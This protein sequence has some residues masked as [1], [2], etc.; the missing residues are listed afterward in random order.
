MRGKKV[1]GYVDEKGKFRHF[2]NDE[3]GLSARDFLMLVV[4]GL[5]SVAFVIGLIMILIV[6]KISKDFFSL[7]EIS[8]PIFITVV[9][10]VMG[11]QAVDVISTAI[12]SKK[13][14]DK[15]PEYDDDNMM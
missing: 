2:G 7:L 13:S 12:T 9:T 3:D 15:D 8:Q 4:V 6:G 10:G 5:F 1:A 14:S 11:V